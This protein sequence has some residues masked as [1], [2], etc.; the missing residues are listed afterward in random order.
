MKKHESQRGY[1]AYELYQQMASNPDIILLVGDLGYL[2]F[3]SI[4]DDYPKQFINCG[5]S[6]QAMLDVAV[7]LALEHKIVF[8][9]TITSFF[10]RAAET[11]GLYVHG[12][13]IP[14]KLVGSGRGQDYKIDGPSHD[15]G[16]A[17]DYLRDLDNIVNLYPDTKEEI[18][19]LVKQMVE[20]KVPTFISLKR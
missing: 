9:Y 2:M 7:G 10:M 12:E 14:V 18:P 17:E 1:F 20:S 4:R 11:I 19:L 13:Q 6:E 15:A 3:D 5:A 8:V 16:I